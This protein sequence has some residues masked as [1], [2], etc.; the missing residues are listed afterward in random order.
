MSL[1][2]RREM[3]DQ[4]HPN[5]PIVRQENARLRFLDEG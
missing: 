2:R 1:G 5:L 4:K 3:V